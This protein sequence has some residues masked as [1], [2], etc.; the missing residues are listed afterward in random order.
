MPL[1]LAA[2]FLLGP[3]VI[4]LLICA[5]FSGSYSIMAFMIAV[6]CGI[7]FVASYVPLRLQKRHFWLY[8]LCYISIPSLFIMSAGKSN[9]HDTMKMWL[10]WGWILLVIYA[11]CLLGGIVGR[12]TG[13]A[14]ARKTNEDLLENESSRGK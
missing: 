12:L 9:P 5:G 2:N 13:K 6:C 3:V 1:S 7:G 4:L 8:G 14:N 11:A 10:T